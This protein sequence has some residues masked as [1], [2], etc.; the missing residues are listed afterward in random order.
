MRWTDREIKLFDFQCRCLEPTHDAG[1]R[2]G[3]QGWQRV[4]YLVVPLRVQFLLPL[5]D[6]LQRLDRGNR[7][8]VNASDFVDQ[9]VVI[10]GEQ[11]H[12]QIAPTPLGRSPF[13]FRPAVLAKVFGFELR[14]DL[15]RPL[16]HFPWDAS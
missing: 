3:G 12:L 8:D 11:R 1:S 14:E 7:I 2:I 16:V 9:R 5:L 10:R 4:A 6:Q 13:D 15:F